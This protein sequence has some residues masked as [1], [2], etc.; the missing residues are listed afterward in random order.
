MK[1]ERTHDKIYLDEYYK[2]NPKEY[3]K[4]VYN[5]MKKDWDDIESKK[6]LDIG[7][8]TGEFLY[9]L[10]HKMPGADLCG[11]DVMQELLNKVDTGIK[12]YC[13]NVSDENTLPSEKFDICTM[14]GVLS[15]FDNHE[16]VLNNVLKLFQEDKVCLYLFGFFNPYDWDV[17]IKARN[18]KTHEIGED[19]TWE[20]G[21]N[22]PSKTSILKYCESKNLQCEFVPFKVD[23]DIEENKDDPLRSWTIGIGNDRLVVNGL[24]L[25]LHFYLCKIHS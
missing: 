6:L 13:A 25:V 20:S 10:K 23:F 18:A 24:Q 11:L 8:A 9:F 15:I 22:Y 7:C 2:T 4:L 16:K 14:M 1:V 3:F 21:W 19:E 5:E 12:T 17:L